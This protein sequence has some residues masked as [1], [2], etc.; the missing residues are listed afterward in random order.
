[1][2]EHQIL[3]IFLL[4]ANH[5]VM[6]PCRNVNNLY[7]FRLSCHLPLQ[8][9]TLILFLFKYKSVN[10]IFASF[11]GIQITQTM[12]LGSIRALISDALVVS[13]TCGRLYQPLKYR[14]EKSL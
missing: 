12:V 1:M 6:A 9:E 2:H 3:K 11:H 13:D 7:G 5:G 14:L 8:N 4:A 10:G